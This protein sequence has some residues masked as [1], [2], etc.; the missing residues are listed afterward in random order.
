[1]PDAGEDLV[2]G[3]HGEPLLVGD[4]PDRLPKVLHRER[5]ADVGRDVVLDRRGRGLQAGG[6]GEDDDRHVVIHLA[7][8]RQD[9]DARQPGHHEIEH[10]DVI[11]PAL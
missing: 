9:I 5:L 7:N 11:V 4:A 2:L 6:P 8:A 3:A 10:E 1:L